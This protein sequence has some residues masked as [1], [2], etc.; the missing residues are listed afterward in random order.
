MARQFMPISPSPPS[1]TIRTLSGLTSVP[2]AFVAQHRP[3]SSPA[4][5]RTHGSGR[6]EA[7]A[8]RYDPR[9][10]MAEHRRVLPE[11]AEKL[12]AEGYTYV[13]VRSVPEFEQGHV[14]GA[15]NVPLL[16]SAAGGMQEN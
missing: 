11:E 2:H 16:H 10:A 3:T 8:L 12:I 1:G 7:G 14:P 13:D 4:P 6:R 15:L 9:R 5:R